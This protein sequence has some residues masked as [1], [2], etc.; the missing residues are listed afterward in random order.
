M[1][2]PLPVDIAKRSMTIGVVPVSVEPIVVDGV[3][4]GESERK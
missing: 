4:Q 1:T 2:T 3:W